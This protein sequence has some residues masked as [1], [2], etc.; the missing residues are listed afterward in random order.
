VTPVLFFDPLS[1][2]IAAYNRAKIIR[3]VVYLLG[4]LVCYVLAWLFFRYGTAMALA[5]FG[6]STEWAIG[7]AIVGLLEA[8]LPLLLWL[9]LLAV[10]TPAGGIYNGLVNQF[11]PTSL[12][13]NPRT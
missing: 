12:Y 1:R 13:L 7:L 10:S 4:S 6:Y 5:S 8:L 3:G 11:D 9:M 2:M